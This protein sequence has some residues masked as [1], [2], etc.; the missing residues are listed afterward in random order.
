MHVSVS[1]DDVSYQCSKA[2]ALNFCQDVP[3]LTTALS[4][5]LFSSEVHYQD[6]V[7]TAKGGQS[8][9]AT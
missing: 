4:L 5:C 3:Y 6:I 9:M 1:P 2:A 7:V 8:L